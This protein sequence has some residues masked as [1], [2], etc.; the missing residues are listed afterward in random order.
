MPLSGSVVLRVYGFGVVQ[1][2]SL[3]GSGKYV[4]LGAAGFWVLCSPCSFGAGGLYG[5]GALCVLLLGCV[6]LVICEILVTVWCWRFVV[7][8]GCVILVRSVLLGSVCDWSMYGTGSYVVPGH[9]V[10][11]GGHV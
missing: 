8:R 1:W 9:C 4:M 10:L 5:N 11:L 6:V 7:H 3:C 2:Q